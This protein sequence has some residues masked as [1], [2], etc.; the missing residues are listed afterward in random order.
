[1]EADGETSASNPR[2]PAKKRGEK[3][4]QKNGRFGQLMFNYKMTGSRF[5]GTGL[6]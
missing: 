6:S 2:K 1:V 5:M 4:G 3:A